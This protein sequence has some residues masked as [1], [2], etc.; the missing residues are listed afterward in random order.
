MIHSPRVAMYVW[1]AEA[2]F[3]QGIDIAVK[4]NAKS[5]EP[6]AVMSLAHFLRREGE[7]L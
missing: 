3:R 4:T 1:E 6:R 7:R 2:N 5:F